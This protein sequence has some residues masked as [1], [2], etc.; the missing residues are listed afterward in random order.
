VA[1]IGAVVAFFFIDSI[2][3]P[4][5]APAEQPEVAQAEVVGV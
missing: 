3:K 2:R 5:A 4:K 1:G